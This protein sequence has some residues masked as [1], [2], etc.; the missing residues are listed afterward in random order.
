V[1]G[2]DIWKST[3]ALDI[4]RSTVAMA[5]KTEFMHKSKFVLF[6]TNA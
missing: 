3:E 1:V 4:E 5:I 6:D 2:R